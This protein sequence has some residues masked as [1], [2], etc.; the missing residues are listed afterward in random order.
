VTALANA[1]IQLASAMAGRPCGGS[2]TMER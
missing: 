1:I 2:V